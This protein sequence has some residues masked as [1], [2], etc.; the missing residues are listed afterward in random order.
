MISTV[1]CVV[2]RLRGCGEKMTASRL[3][4]ANM[5]TPGGVSSGFVVGTRDAISPTGFAYLTMPCSG[6]SSMTPTLGWR[7]T[8]RRM[9][10]TLNRLP[11]A[12]HGSPMPLSSTPIR[13]EA[14]ERRLVRDRPGHRL[15]QAVDL[16]LRG[17]P[18]TRAARLARARPARRPGPSPPG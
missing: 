12:A 18:R 5:P 7:S 17:A 16:R 2:R 15:A 13:R 6:S 10:M 9:P 8:S 4:M 14:R 1:S 11:I 3:L